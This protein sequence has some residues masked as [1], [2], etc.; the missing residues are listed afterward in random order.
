MRGQTRSVPSVPVPNSNLPPSLTPRNTHPTLNANNG[1]RTSLL[2]LGLSVLNMGS[3]NLGIFALCGTE[4]LS[5]IG[6]IMES[7]RT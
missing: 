1:P 6:R 5:E 4:G 2:R 7:V 3:G